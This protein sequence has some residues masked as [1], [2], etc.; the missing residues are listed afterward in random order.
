MEN[1][2]EVYK[3]SYDPKRPVVCLDEK[4]KQLVG[5]I[6]RSIYPQIQMC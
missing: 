1:V 4:S 3:R 2:L 5:E 6:C